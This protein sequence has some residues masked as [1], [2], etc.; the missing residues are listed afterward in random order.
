M[1]VSLRAFE[2]VVQEELKKLPKVFRDRLK[3]VMVVI[4][5]GPP[6]ADEGYDESREGDDEDEL[7]GLY[8]GVPL[9]ELTVDHAADPPGTIT[10]FKEEIEAEAEE[11][12]VD[13]RAHIRRVL[14]HEV[15][16]HFGISDER[17]EELGEY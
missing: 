7:T 4:E 15:A 10:L 11:E 3:N 16:H 5:E 17:L 2:A 9:T 1:A 13:L 8:E 14:R 6:P 12:G